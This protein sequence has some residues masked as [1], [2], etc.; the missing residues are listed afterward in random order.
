MEFIKKLSPWYGSSGAVEKRVP[1]I[2]PDF[3]FLAY[4]SNYSKGVAYM[5]IKFSK[6]LVLKKNFQEL[7]PYGYVRFM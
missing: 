7:M 3:V 2:F 6:E 5:G 4:T 1:H